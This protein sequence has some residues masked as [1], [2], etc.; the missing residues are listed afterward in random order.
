M[1][2][3]WDLVNEMREEAKTAWL[4]AIVVGFENETKF[5]FSSNNQSLEELNRLI[6][7]GGAPVG[8]LRFEKENSTIQGSYRPF[9]EYGNET[10]VKEYLKG[11]LESAEKII[12]LASQ[13]V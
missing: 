13:R 6:Q 2:N 1:R 9:Q 5:V 8:L 4:V 11:L 10:W 12:A 3:T 7:S